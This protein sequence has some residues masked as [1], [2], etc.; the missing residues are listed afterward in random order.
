[1][2]G[3]PIVAIFGADLDLQSPGPAPEYDAREME[4]RCYPDDGEIERILAEVRPDVLL[5]VGQVEDYPRLLALP[6]D[7][8]RRWLH[9]PDAS[10]PGTLG[11]M[12][13]ACFLESA[14]EHRPG[15]PLLV[16]VFTPAYR[17]GKRIVRAYRSLLVQDYP[18]W[19][20]VLYD[21]SDDGGETWGIVSAIAAGDHR[22][23]AY[24]ASRHSGIVGAV[25]RDAALL[26]RGEILLEL[27]HDDELRADAL[28]RVVAAFRANPR[29]GFVYSDTEM[30]GPDGGWRDFGPS[31]AHGYGETREVDGVLAHGATINAA[32][33]RHIVGA[34]NHLRAWR[35]GAYRVAGAHN[36]RLPIVDDYDLLVRTFLTTRMHRLA[37]PL[38]VQHIG[39]TTTDA[40]RRAIQRLVRHVAAHYDRAIH[41]RL[42]DLGMDGFLWDEQEGRADWALLPG[43]ES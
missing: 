41:V 38:Y 31:W 18:E 33:S 21:D 10:D 34:P 28:D 22:V 3:L 13:W 19:E 32:T 6:Y 9:A 23:R 5:S 2:H 43:A 35:Q 24:R 30:R 8:R 29:V 14:L 4:C 1:M 26:C 37:L 15:A 16:S 42:I 7:V 12:A 20:W 11:R 36:A 17:G 25:K 39:D 40:R 27:D